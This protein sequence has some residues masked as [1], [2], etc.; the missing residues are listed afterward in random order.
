[1]GTTSSLWGKENYEELKEGKIFMV[2]IIVGG[3]PSGILFYDQGFQVKKIHILAIKMWNCKW[4]LLF[5]T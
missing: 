4:K 2:T 3:I 5:V 1:M